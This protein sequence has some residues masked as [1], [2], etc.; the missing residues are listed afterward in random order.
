MDVNGDGQ[1]EYINNHHYGKCFRHGA[2]E[3]AARERRGL[4]T[5]CASNYG[6]ALGKRRDS[7]VRPVFEWA[8]QLLHFTDPVT[9]G[10]TDSDVY[11]QWDCHGMVVADIDGDGLQV[12]HALPLP[13]F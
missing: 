1:L 5:G 11:S 4:K 10:R 8:E 7:A 3:V 2:N 13:P 6:W 9:K 12:R